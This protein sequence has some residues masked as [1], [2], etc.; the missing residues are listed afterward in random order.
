[1]STKSVVADNNNLPIS[2][3]LLSTVSENGYYCDNVGTESYEAA[4]ASVS[5][6]TL[7]VDP[8]GKQPVYTVSTS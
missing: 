2:S 3:F 7:Q 5:P 8:T 6:F 1:M 4:K